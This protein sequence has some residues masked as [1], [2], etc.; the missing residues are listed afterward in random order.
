MMQVWTN[1]IDNAIKFSNNNGIITV[2]AH[3]TDS[4]II[5]TVEDRGIGMTEEVRDRVFERFF[6]GDT[7]HK[8]QGNGL[9]LSIVKSIVEKSGG[10]I[11]VE[12]TWEEAL[13]LPLSCLN[14]KNPKNCKVLNKSFRITLTALKKK[15]KINN[16]AAEKPLPLPPFFYEIFVS[17]ILVIL[18]FHFCCGF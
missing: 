15:T 5:V 6:Q 14:L 1:L 13:N 16:S 10:T 11:S 9:G 18:F 3:E 2:T 8:E 12:S 7:S 4:Y 17:N